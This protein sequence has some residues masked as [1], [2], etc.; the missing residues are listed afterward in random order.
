V[1]LY[2]LARSGKLEQARRMQ[3][4]LLLASNLIVAEAG[5]AGVKFAMDQRGYRGGLPRRPLLPL[6]DSLKARIL[7]T[8]AAIDAVAASA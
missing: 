3:Q 1:A 4:S 2:Q 5:I 6:A 7:R 8:V